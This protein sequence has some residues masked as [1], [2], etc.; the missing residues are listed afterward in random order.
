MKSDER[1][2]M[3]G[4]TRTPEEVTTTIELLPTF[5]R[6]DGAP[7]KGIGEWYRMVCKCGH[8]QEDILFAGYDYAPT[9]ECDEC[10]RS[11]RFDRED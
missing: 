1:N 10:C 4:T 3:T 2:R 5:R 9:A 11:Y 8:T 6:P 7:V